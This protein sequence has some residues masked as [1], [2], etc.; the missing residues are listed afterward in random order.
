MEQTHAHGGLFHCST[1]K[2]QITGMEKNMNRYQPKK[3]TNPVKAI[4]EH[5]IECMGGRGTGQNF[6]KLIFE[7]PS[8]D[9]AVYEFRLGKNPFRKPVSDANRK[10]LSGRAKRMNE[11]RGGDGFGPVI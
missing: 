11:Q 9:C 5:C 8:P 7:C 3:Q 4:R 2:P 1:L 10:I 6:T